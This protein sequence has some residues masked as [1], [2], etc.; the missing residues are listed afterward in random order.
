MTKAPTRCEYEDAVKAIQWAE[1]R[2][3]ELEEKIAGERGKIREART[4]VMAYVQERI[5]KT[6]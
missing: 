6:R 4:V 1:V 5:A 3:S 2:I